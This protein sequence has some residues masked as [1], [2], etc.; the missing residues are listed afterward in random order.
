MA[1]L[2]ERGIGDLAPVRSPLVDVAR[3][4]GVSTAT[5]DRVLNN[6]GR[7]R[8]RTRD[9]VLGAAARLGYISQAGSGAPI[10]LPPADD[11]VQ[12]HFVLP[13]GNNSFIAAL[14]RQ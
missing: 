5:V 10:R 13:D 3:E 11:V 12:L 8:S 6:R 2:A 4:A 9:L 7:A 1:E 14:H